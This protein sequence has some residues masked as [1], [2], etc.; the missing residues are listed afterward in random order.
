MLLVTGITGHTGRYF[1]EELVNRK[2]NGVI[3]CLV[4]KTTN[5][6]LLN[7]SPLNIEVVHGD[8]NNDRSIDDVM[9]GVE[10]VIHIYNIHNSISIVKSAIKHQVKKVVLVHTTGIYSNFKEASARYIEIEKE[11]SQI[12]KTNSNIDVIILRPSMIYGDM[13]DHN[14]SKFIK[15]I[16]KFKFM[17]VIDGGKSLIQ[18]VN[19][20]DLGKAYYVALTS[21]HGQKA[22]DLTGDR[23][24]TLKDAYKIIAS[25]LNKK[26]YFINIPLWLGIIVARFIKLVTL[27]KLNIVEKVQRMA[28]NRSYSH[29]EA[30]H[31]FNFSPLTFE[32]GIHLEVQ[33]YLKKSRG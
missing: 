2:Y 27:D 3:R 22:Y 16:D 15:V 9:K 11:I 28:E 25:K 29:A 31:D 30:K 4:R 7:N 10:E 23:P 14:M 12:L 13:C 32:E 17:P 5:T 21:L 19:A 18:P 26:I 24:I 33:Q 8:I 6:S 1:Y 20:R